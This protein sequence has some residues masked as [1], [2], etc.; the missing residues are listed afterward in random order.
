MAEISLIGFAL[1]LF[2]LA[3]LA[4]RKNKGLGDKVL[5]VFI[6]LLGLKLS[7]LAIEYKGWSSLYIFATIGD[8]FYWCLLG[9]LLFHFVQVTLQGS[10]RLKPLYLL[11]LLPL[12]LV[13]GAFSGYLLNFLTKESFG[14]YLDSHQTLVPTAGY[15]LFIF[16]SPIYFIAALFV[17]VKHRRSIVSFYS[18]TQKVDLGWLFYV[19]IGFGTYLVA[20]LASMLLS[21]FLDIQLPFSIYRYTPAILV[22]YLFGLGYTG[23]LRLP[24]FAEFQMFIKPDV[25]D[26]DTESS[27]LTTGR[28]QKSGLSEKEA[29]EIIRQLNQY[30]ELKKP[31][32]DENLNLKSLAEAMGTSTHKLSQAL[33]GQLRVSF[34]EYI[35]DLR[36]EEVKK[37]LT[38]AAYEQFTLQAIAYDSGFCSKSTFYTTFR[39]KTGMTPGVFLKKRELQN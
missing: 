6:L 4:A 36:I 33:N 9:P 30:M 37:R 18:N 29:L 25:A 21:R 2:I 35:N 13:S 12:I 26:T 39:K 17:L 1:A 19:T 32:L 34:F 5:L 27:L 31:Y 14:A 24:G 20:G 23:I 8:I 7:G 28:Y 10:E 11:H 16:V 15:Y 3:V 38:D 22:V